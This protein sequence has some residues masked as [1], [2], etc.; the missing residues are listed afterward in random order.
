MKKLIQESFALLITHRQLLTLSIGLIVLS[1]AL[2][3]YVALSVQPSELQLV[4]HCSAFGVTHLYRDQWFYLFS[5]GIFGLLAAAIHV[6]LSAKVLMI[7]GPSL[8]ALFLWAGIAIVILA[9]VTAYPVI[10]IFN[11]GDCRTLLG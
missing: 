3:I 7:K 9:W 8:A 5:F 11:I 4:S 1:I 10:N 2:A 6:M